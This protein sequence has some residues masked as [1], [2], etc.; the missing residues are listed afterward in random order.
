M[1][2]ER[3]IK[4]TDAVETEFAK[5]SQHSRVYMGSWFDTTSGPSAADLTSEELQRL[6]SKAVKRR[7]PPC[8]TTACFAGWACFMFSDPEDLRKLIETDLTRDGLTWSTEAERL[9]GISGAFLFHTSGSR[10]VGMARSMIDEA[11][12]E[13]GAP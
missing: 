1:N 2:I 7:E 5:S 4:V 8:G 6:A 10:V 9:L 3:M 13:G 12:R 11:R